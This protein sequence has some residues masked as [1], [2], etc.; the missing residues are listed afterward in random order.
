VNNQTID[1]GNRRRNRHISENICVWAFQ[2]RR[3]KTHSTRTY[4]RRPIEGSPMASAWIVLVAYSFGGL[5]L[6]SEGNLGAPDL[7][8]QSK[9]QCYK[10]FARY[11]ANRYSGDR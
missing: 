2:Q 7:V 5:E 10:I 1:S 11:F 3:V 9:R 4:N 8:A 6:G